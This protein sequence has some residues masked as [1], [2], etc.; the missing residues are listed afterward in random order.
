MASFREELERLR[1]LEKEGALGAVKDTPSDVGGGIVDALTQGASMGWGDEL[2]ALEAGVLGRTP[3]GGWFDYSKPFGERYDD[4]LTAERQQ[5]KAFR[6]ANPKTALAAEV[7]GGLASAIAGPGALAARGVG[8]AT[9]MARPAAQMAARS[10]SLPASIGRGIGAGATQGA[11][12]GA[13]EAEGDAGDIAQGALEGAATGG[14]LGGAMR[15]VGERLSGMLRRVAER[16]PQIDQL[17]TSA[18]AV[19]DQLRQQNAPMRGYGQFLRGVEDDLARE[20]IDTAT[21]PRVSQFMRYAR[22]ILPD[23]GSPPGY[24]QLQNLRKVADKAANS[25]DSTEKYLGVVLRERLDEFVYDALE[26]GGPA[27][28]APH[29]FQRHGWQCHQQPARRSEAAAYEPENGSLL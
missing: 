10:T 11:I 25:N 1:A 6:T 16:R 7:G 5:Q 17:K 22:E 8:L 26:A 28:P 20:M 12:Y 21:E 13:G 24:G 19:F 9:G 15:P 23:D 3:D 29:R 2:T 4:A 27:G 14:I 18:G